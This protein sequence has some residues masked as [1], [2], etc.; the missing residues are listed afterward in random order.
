VIPLA[1]H[2]QMK[3]RTLEG[4]GQRLKEIRQSRALSQ[5]ALGE[6]VGVSQRVVA[7]YESD[8]AQPP[9]ALLADLARTLDV[10]ADE[11][12]GIEP[13]K[14]KASPKRARLRKR[15]QRVEQLPAA[16]QRAVLKFVDALVESRGVENGS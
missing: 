14:E 16:D 4:F 5:Q 7:Y 9:G 13:L 15:L 3:E 1:R 6:L 8:A 11:L 2:D 10:T 12:L